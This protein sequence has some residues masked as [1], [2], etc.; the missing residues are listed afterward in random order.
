M[1]NKYNVWITDQDGNRSLLTYRDRTA[2]TFRTAIKHAED[3]VE[4]FGYLYSV[5]LE[6]DL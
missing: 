2:W 5:V 4:K 3:F 1:S 6:V